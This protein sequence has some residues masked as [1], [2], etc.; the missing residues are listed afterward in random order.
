VAWLDYGSYPGP[1]RNAI[2]AGH[3]SWRGR[4]GTLWKLD[5][6]SEGAEVLVDVDGTTHT[7]VVRWVRLYDPDDAPVSELLGETE[8]HSLTLITCGGRFDRARGGYE[9]RVVVRAEIVESQA[10]AG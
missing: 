10:G 3:R 4:Q 6:V 2:L 8:V 9:M 1:Y 7:Y 5:Q